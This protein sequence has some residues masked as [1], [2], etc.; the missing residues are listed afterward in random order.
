MDSFRA[1][2]EE[3]GRVT[4]LLCTAAVYT[5]YGVGTIRAH[6]DPA[7]KAV[8][9]KLKELTPETL[10]MACHAYSE[11]KALGKEAES[12]RRAK[13]KARRGDIVGAAGA[14]WQGMTS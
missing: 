14:A 12:F 3:K 2:L 8:R 11:G 9:R 4:R 5:G 6:T 1:Q 7:L 10:L 13:R